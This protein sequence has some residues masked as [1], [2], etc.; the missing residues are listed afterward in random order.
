MHYGVSNP[1]PR[2][3]ADE[4]VP[5]PVN[6]KQAD[7]PLREAEAIVRAHDTST[8]EGFA[9]ACANGLAKILPR[10]IAEGLVGT[11]E[12]TRR[13]AAFLADHAHGRP[14]QAVTMH[15]SGRVEHVAPP[16]RWTDEAVVEAVIEATRL[17]DSA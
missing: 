15:H 17:D 16:I 14:V 2:I 13:I 8:P 10:L 3:V 1:Y 12:T 4:F 9:S 6:G 5:Q 7:D 11:A